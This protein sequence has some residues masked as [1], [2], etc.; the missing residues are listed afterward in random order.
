MLPTAEKWRLSSKHTTSGQLYV[1]TSNVITVSPLAKSYCFQIRESQVC[2]VILLR[3][4]Q[5]IL[6]MYVRTAPGQNTV[7][8][9]DR[10]GKE[11]VDS[12]NL[13]FF[14]F[15]FRN[16]KAMAVATF[17]YRSSHYLNFNLYIG[18]VI[19]SR[20]KISGCG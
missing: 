20:D 18:L 6:I 10:V 7:A 8:R 5:Y 1:T 19:S 12:P 4:E 9:P 3:G 13:L 17:C 14:V 15:F 2:A 16:N 11:A